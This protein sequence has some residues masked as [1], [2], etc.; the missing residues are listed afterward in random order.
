MRLGGLTYFSEIKKMKLE[1]PNNF[2]W[3]HV[4]KFFPIWRWKLVNK[5]GSPLQDEYPWLTFAAVQFL[6][7]ILNPKMRVFEYG[8][9]GSTLFFVR[10]VH[11]VISIEHDSTWL[12]K[13]SAIITQHGYQNWQGV[14]LEP[15]PDQDF[16][17][18]TP[19]N[20]DTYQ[21]DE[22]LY[23]GKTFRNYASYIDQYPNAYFD[24]ILIDG[25]AR[26]SCFKHALQKIKQTGYII[27][28]NT[29]RIHYFP[30]MS[31][32][33]PQM[34]CKHLP[35]PTPYAEFFTKTSIWYYKTMKEELDY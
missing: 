4:L 30:A 21:S 15:T 33:S 11:T 2:V 31:L 18:H 6:K 16:C 17:K 3:W 12:S 28:D 1:Y 22:P 35:G 24:I 10:R 34:I 19:S 26:P 29:E 32:A 7:T 25:R 23:R 9:G 14:V 27:W 5:Q 13:V 8:V 20:P